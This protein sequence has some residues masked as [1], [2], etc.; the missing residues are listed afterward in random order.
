MKVDRNHVVHAGGFKQVG[1]ELRRD[2]LARCGL[3]V[4]TRIAEVSD[5]GRDGTGSRA[6]GGI[7][8][9]QKLHERVVDVSTSDGLDQ[10]HIGAAHALK[11]ARIDFAVR[12][13]L[14]LHIAKGNSQLIG[15]LISKLGVHGTAENGYA[16]LHFGHG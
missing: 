8:H 7:D 11:I 14:E 1:H 10:E 3:T 6:L 13:L 5:N 9:D 15:N 16:L 2:G 12:K 4:L